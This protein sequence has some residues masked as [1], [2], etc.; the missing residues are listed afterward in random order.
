MCRLLQAEGSCAGLLPVGF[1][2]PAAGPS[3]V[4]LAASCLQEAEAAAH[5]ETALLLKVIS[6]ESVQGDPGTTSGEEE[7]L[8]EPEIP[9]LWQEDCAHYQVTLLGRG[10]WGLP[11]PYL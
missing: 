9:G 8:A 3:R 2:L 4:C 11:G 6:S 10:L 5:P 1:L 7:T